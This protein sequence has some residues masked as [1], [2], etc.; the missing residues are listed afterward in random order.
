MLRVIGNV[1]LENASDS[2]EGFECGE[3]PG[4][5]NKHYG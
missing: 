1:V 3:H 2:F 4:H 5:V